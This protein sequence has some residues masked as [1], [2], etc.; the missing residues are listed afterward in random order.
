MTE[1]RPDAKMKELILYIAERSA[2]DAFFGAIKLNKILFYSDFLAYGH[3]GESITGQAYFRMPLGPGP[4]R[5]VPIQEEMIENEDIVLQSVERY[6]FRQ[7]RVVPLRPANLEMFQPDQLEL[8]QE[9]IELFRNK[10]AMEASDLSHTFL[11]WELVNDFEDIP[12]STVF[13]SRDKPDVEKY[14][15][16]PQSAA[17]STLRRLPRFSRGRARAHTRA[18]RQIGTSPRERARLGMAS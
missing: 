16:S 2:D 7:K 17:G 9:V 5:L 8:V 3:F 4:R 12:Y 14:R 10:S 1:Y 11:G 13:L 6:T 15:A 18:H